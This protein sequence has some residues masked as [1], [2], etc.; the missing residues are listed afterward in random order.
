MHH[1]LQSSLLQLLDSFEQMRFGGERMLL[2]LSTLSV[3][4][5]PVPT[6]R[7]GALFLELVFTVRKDIL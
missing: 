7:L 1:H 3:P 2:A 4:K 6:Y 5:T